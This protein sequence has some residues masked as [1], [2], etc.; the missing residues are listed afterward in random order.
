MNHLWELSKKNFKVSCLVNYTETPWSFNQVKRSAV[1]YLNESLLT[2]KRDVPQLEL[3]L[4]QCKLQW[5]RGFQRMAKAQASPGT[6][7]LFRKT[8]SQAPRRP[9]NK[10]LR[11]DGGRARNLC[12]KKPSRWCW[13]QL[14]CEN[15]RR[16]HINKENP[17]LGF[18]PAFLFSERRG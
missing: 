6:G 5:S 2:K 8:D 13:R 10:K 18:D 11:R 3:T 14:K 7:E 12:L 15:P 16:Q 4:L 17:T 1:K 9:R